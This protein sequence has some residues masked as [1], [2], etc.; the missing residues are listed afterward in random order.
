MLNEILRSSLCR[1][2]IPNEGLELYYGGCQISD[3]QRFDPLDQFVHCKQHHIALAAFRNLVVMNSQSDSLQIGNQLHWK[4]Q[5]TA[6]LA[7]CA[8]LLKN[9]YSNLLASTSV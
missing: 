9:S 5:V 1:R 3:K 7:F 6:L 4:L 8:C 2:H